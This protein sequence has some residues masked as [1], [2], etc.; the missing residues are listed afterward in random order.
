VR[1]KGKLFSRDTLIRLKVQELASYIIGRRNELDFEE[2][3]PSF[4][5]TDSE[6]IRRMIRSMTTTEASA[7]GVRKST[8]WYLKKRASS[9]KPL[10]IY[11]KVLSRLSERR[12]EPLPIQNETPHAR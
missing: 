10:K 12:R 8:L 6:A 9:R 5:N 1:Y 11:G 3:S 2:P 7:L 4:D